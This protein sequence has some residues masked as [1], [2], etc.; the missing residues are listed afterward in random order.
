MAGDDYM[1]VQTIRKQTFDSP[2]KISIIVPIKDRCGA[3]IRNCLRGIRLQSYKGIEIIIVDYGSTKENHEQ[4]LKD[5]EPFDCTF[6]RYPTQNIWSPAVAKNIGIR[7]AQGEYI[8]TLDADCIMEP[9]VIEWTLKLHGE[10]KDGFVETKMCFLLPAVEVDTLNLPRDFGKLRENYSL[11]K[12]GFGAYLSVHRSWWLS[13]RGCDERFQGWGGNDDDIRDRVKRSE[14]RRNVLSERVKPETMIFHQW[15]P[16]SRSEFTKKYGK[17]YKEMYDINVS[18]INR[19]KTSV[20][21]RDNDNW[22][23]FY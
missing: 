17:S 18:I 8:A 13:V 22:G 10:H 23:V 3:R 5:S 21:N 11:R 14:F 6:Y 20:R 2:P 19:D 12:Y 4:L 7:R 1:K 15:H 9:K 16:S